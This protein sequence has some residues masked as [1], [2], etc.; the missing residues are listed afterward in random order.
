MSPNY[1]ILNPF[2]YTVE[3]KFCITIE[4]NLNQ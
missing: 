3:L 1:D 2:Q 4:S